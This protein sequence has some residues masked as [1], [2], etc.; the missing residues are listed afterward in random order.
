MTNYTDYANN[1]R[2]YL[3][4]QYAAEDRARARM[5]VERE[6]DRI[7]Q[8]DIVLSGLA[9]VIIYYFFKSIFWIIKWICIGIWMFFKLLFAPRVGVKYKRLYQEEYEEFGQVQGIEKWQK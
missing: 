4:D 7:R 9:L 5:A 2:A 6:R 8:N 3:Q 1:R